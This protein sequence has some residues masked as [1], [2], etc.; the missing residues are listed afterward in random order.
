MRVLITGATGA[1]GSAVADSLLARGDEVV[2]LT[3]DPEKA[4]GSNPTAR[5]HKWE[6]TLER[7][8]AEAFEAVDGVINLVGEPIDQR[9]TDEA[10]KSIMES[11]TVATKNLVEAI[12]SLQAKPSVLVSGSAIGYYG[13]RGDTL[14]DESS[15]AGSDFAAEVV[16]AWEK[17]ADE[18]E[19]AGVRLVK[20]RTGLVLNPE[21]GLLK[22]L[23]PP[24][25]MGV[26]GPL[27]GG[28]QYMPWVHIDDE[29]GVLLWALDSASVSGVVNATAPNPVT[30]KDFSKALGR[31]INRPA[32]LPTPGF[33]VNLVLGKEAAEHTAKAGARVLPRRTQDLGYTF[34]F[35]EIDAAFAD[36][37][38][39]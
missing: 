30:N 23:L 34:R 39:D 19:V 17:E 20:V 1:I 26:G 38:G 32:V 21:S 33:A 27:A 37:F 13:D 12:A 2:G 31:A 28:K 9:W 10:K 11:R 14:I 22:R 7:P 24:F 35:T 25:R 3:R 5:W 18:V 4:R 8:P 15:S 36:L 16:K 29:V 6:P